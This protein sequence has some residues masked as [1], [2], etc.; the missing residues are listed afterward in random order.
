MTWIFEVLFSKR[1]AKSML[2]VVSSRARIWDI[3]SVIE[4]LSAVISNWESAP[5]P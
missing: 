2:S 1:S 5:G 4:T 3:F